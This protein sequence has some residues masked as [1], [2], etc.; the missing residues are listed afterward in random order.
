MKMSGRLV[1]LQDGA[2]TEVHTV[3]EVN[4]VGV[5]AQLGGRMIQDVSKVMFKD[6][7]KRFQQ[8]LQADSSRAAPDPNAPAEPV[9]AVRV[10]GQAI[11]EAIGRTFRRKHGDL[12][13]SGSD[14][15]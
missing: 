8:Q 5:L 14:Q 11:S 15:S 2:A 7:V 10:V 3:S 1:A 9:Q 6:F 13:E 12:D 4:V